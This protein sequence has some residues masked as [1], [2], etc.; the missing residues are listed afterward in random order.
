MVKGL[1]RRGRA[2]SCS[3]R[4]CRGVG[5]DLQ[6]KDRCVLGPSKEQLTRRQAKQEEGGADRTEKATGWARTSGGT[7]PAGDAVTRFTL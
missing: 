1:S 4:A 5:F 7:P 3:P 2:L 6:Q